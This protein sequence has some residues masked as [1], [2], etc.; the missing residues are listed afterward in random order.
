MSLIPC[1]WAERLS[2]AVIFSN[3]AG[4]RDRDRGGDLETGRL[5]DDRSDNSP[6]PGSLQST[7]RPSRTP[8]LIVGEVLEVPGSACSCFPV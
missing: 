8:R 4:D 6:T 5:W 7:G 2:A 3:A 1:C